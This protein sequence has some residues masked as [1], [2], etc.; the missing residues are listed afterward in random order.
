MN[1]AE[2]PFS[3]D[4]SRTTQHGLR[5]DIQLLRALAILLVVAQH[6]NLTIVSGG[7]LGVDVFFVVSGY[8]MTGIIARELDEGRFSFVSF[9]ARRARR[10]L[11]AAMATFAVTALTAPW[12]LDTAELRDFVKQLLGS[13]VFVGNIVL[14][15][16]SDYF[17]SGAALKPLL[18]TWSLSVEE[19]YYILL[20]LLLFVCPARLRLGLTA[21]LTVGSLALCLWLQPR[22]PSGVFYLL[23]FRAWELGIGSAVA[24]LV[25]GGRLPARPM[26]LLRGLTAVVLLVLPFSVS[27]AGHPGWPALVACLAT[28]VLVVPG[29]DLAPSRGLAPLVGI[30]NRSYTLYLVHWPVFAFANNIFIESVPVWAGAVAIALVLTWMELQYRLVEQPLRT[31]RVGRW[32]VAGFVGGGVLI[33]AASLGAAMLL[34]GRA[35]DRAANTGLGLACAFRDRLEDLPECRTAAQPRTLLWGDSIAIA[36]APGLAQ[37]S[38]GGIVQ[39]TKTVC[40]PFLDIAPV[41]DGSHNARWA[42]DCIAFN[43]SVL[44]SLKRSPQIE[45]VVLSSILTQYAPGVEDYRLMTRNGAIATIGPQSVPAVIA[46]LHRTAEAVRRLGKRVVLVAPPPSIGYDIGRCEVRLA[47]ARLTSAPLG[48]CSFSESAYHHYRAPLLDLLDAARR[49]GVPVLSL[50]PAICASGTCRARIGTTILY[51]DEVHLSIA[52]SRLLGE[53]MRWG[54]AAARLAR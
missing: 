25:R 16:Q 41:D 29:L 28:A 17:S 22:F 9:Y 15:R 54:E 19:Q 35:A 46:S 53:S 12:V 23:P 42:R 40:G 36:L 26:P 14:W 31:M 20:P 34:P 21:L 32:Q 50:D 5:I 6:A 45:T 1:R 44:A 7:F 30:G 8:L 48:G 4:V 49:G 39:A 13:L 3:L 43:D 10:L 47:E 11:P 18:H 51:R 24:L 2:V 38:P 52:G 33:G 37:S 27:E